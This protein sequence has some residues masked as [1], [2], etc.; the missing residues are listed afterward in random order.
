MISDCTCKDAKKSYRMIDSINYRMHQIE[1]LLAVVGI[2]E[3]IV[4]DYEARLDELTTLRE[5]IV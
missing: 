5:S 3:P 2:P 4:R 1:L